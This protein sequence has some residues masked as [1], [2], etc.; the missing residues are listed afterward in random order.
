M[1]NTKEM[2]KR[3][4]RREQMRRKEMRSRLFGIGLISI[5]AI[6]VAILFIYP[7]FKP[8][9]AITTPETFVRPNA[10]NNAAGNPEAPIKI[11]EYS[12]FQCPYCRVFFED[13][14]GS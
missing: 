8:V 7:N 5:G 3:Q 9:G 10:K 12:D 4:A 11:D 6:L 2:S 14:E 13:T 1:S